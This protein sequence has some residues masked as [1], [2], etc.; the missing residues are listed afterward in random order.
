MSNEHIDGPEPESEPP[1][2]TIYMRVKWSCLG[3][4][5]VCLSG[6]VKVRDG[7]EWCVGVGRGQGLACG[8]V[9][10]V[11]SK[12]QNNTPSLGLDL[13]RQRAQR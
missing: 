2:K 6:W 13:G 9:I 3:L 12:L 7:D 5:F 4:G 1:R 10:K 11:T 8:Q